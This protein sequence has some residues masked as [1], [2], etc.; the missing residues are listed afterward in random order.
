M[1]IKKASLRS[2]DFLPIEHAVEMT[3]KGV[4]ISIKIEVVQGHIHA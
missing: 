4:I 3:V 1:S 2:I